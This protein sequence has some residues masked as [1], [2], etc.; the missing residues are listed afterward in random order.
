MYIHMSKSHEDESIFFCRAFRL[1]DIE[2][3]YKGRHAIKNYFKTRYY[4][5]STSG[6]WRLKETAVLKPK[7]IT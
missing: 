1:H 5:A 2:I 7:L 3:S 4:K 6:G